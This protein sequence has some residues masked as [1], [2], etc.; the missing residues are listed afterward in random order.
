MIVYPTHICASDLERFGV[1][2]VKSE[3]WELTK[4]I[5][6]QLMVTKPEHRS[7]DLIIKSF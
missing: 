2:D 3:I 6:E 1:L 7:T 4:I 5:I